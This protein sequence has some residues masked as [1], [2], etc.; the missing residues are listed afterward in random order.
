V[1]VRDSAIIDFTEAVYDL[2]EPDDEW[3]SNLLRAGGPVLDHGLGVFALRCVRPAEA[4]PLEIEGLHVASGAGDF[5]KGVSDLQREIDMEVL[6]PLSRPGMPK[7]L[8]EVTDKHN[9]AAFR[10][11]MQHFGFA[12]DGLGLSAFEPS[13]RGI[14][15]IIAL[16]K[17]TTLSDRARERWQMLAAHFGAGYRLRRALEKSPPAPPA[18]TG[19]PFGAE[20]VIDPSDFRVADATGE[21]RSRPALAALREAAEHVDRARGRLRESDPEKALELWKALVRGRWS[22]VDWFDS[23]GRRYVLGIPN[24]PDVLDPR[25]LTER[26]QQVVSFAA[27]GMTSKMIGYNLGVSKGRVSTLLSSA[28]KKLGVQTRAQLIKKLK[29]FS[30]VIE[31]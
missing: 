3:I 25:G 1:T 23:D 4:G 28:M 22:T 19:M 11:I 20:I 6:W 24:P 7:T 14:Y 29:D 31:Q 15:M 12:K 8:S 21:A 30:S 26:E 17:V 2:G 5:V 9:P 13:G 10:T 18:E 16:P 27:V